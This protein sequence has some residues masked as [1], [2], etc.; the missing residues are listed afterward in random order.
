MMS[1]LVSIVIPT[2]NRPAL[3]AEAIASALGQVGFDDFEV[4]VL[5]NNDSPQDT[6]PSETLVESF[7]DSRL[8][9]HRNP[10]NLGMT[11]NWNRGIELARGQW[12]TLL[13]DD[14][15][16]CPSFLDRV[17]P[18]FTRADL[19]VCRVTVGRIPFSHGAL[20]PPHKTRP[21]RRLTKVDLA[22]SNPSPAPGV[23]F[24]RE[25]ALHLG[26][27]NED[28]YPCADYEFWIRCVS[29]L[30]TFLL[31]ECLAHYRVLDNESLQTATRIQIA[32]MAGRLQQALVGRMVPWARLS[33]FIAS[34]GVLSLL[35]HY[36]EDPKFR[37]SPE[38]AEFAQQHGYHPGAPNW[39]IRARVKLA[40]YLLRWCAKEG[41]P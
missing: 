1:P 25:S 22:F 21:A 40:K 16:L 35:H 12:V 15:L 31:P 18:L 29:E 19:I 7:R 41:R 38:L 36:C 8:R 5:D 14:D 6:V 39:Q 37:D 27:F 11:G 26:G 9:Y 30:E 33:R 4:L 23:I 34:T 32:E 2:Y 10:K 24:R 13:H 3:L 17:A 20:R 28:W